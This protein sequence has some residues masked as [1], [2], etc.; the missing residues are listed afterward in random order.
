MLNPESTSPT[1]TARGYKWFFRTT[2][3][4]EMFAKQ[5]VDF[6]NWLNKKYGNQIKRIAIIHEDTEWGTA[7]ARA[8]Q[9]YF[10]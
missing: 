3:H 4:D 5:H 7:T 10:T 6:V 2:P 8:W 9:K 1:L